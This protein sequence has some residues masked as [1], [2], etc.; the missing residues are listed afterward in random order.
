ML[1]IFKGRIDF[2]LCFI[3][4]FSNHKLLNHDLNGEL[5]VFIGREAELQFLESRYRANAGQLVVLYGRRRIGKT[6]TLRQFCKG[7]PHVFFACQECTD[8]LQLKNFSEK[9]LREDIP[10][11]QY[12]EQFADWE[13]AY[14]AVMDLPYGDKKKLLIIDE[15]PYMCKSNSGIPSILQNLW[16]EKLKNANVMIILCGSAMSFIE[17]ELLAKKNPL[18]GRATGIY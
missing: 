11:K 8:K 16:D 2:L 1:K 13:K 5:F 9:M 3:Y 10:V 4:N 14:S 18:Y 15:F 17:K 6:E 12:I 7:K